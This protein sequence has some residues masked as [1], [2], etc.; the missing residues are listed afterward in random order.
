MARMHIRVAGEDCR[1]LDVGSRL[2][3]LLADGTGG[4]AM[5]TAC[6]LNTRRY[7]GHLVA[8]V[9]PPADRM[10]LLD[11][12]EAFAEITGTSYPLA[13][14][15]YPGALHPEGYRHL[16]SFEATDSHVE[17]TFDLGGNEV[18]KRLTLTPEGCH[19]TFENLSKRP[20][21][22]YVRPLVCHK[23]YHANFRARE[24]YPSGLAVDEDSLSI[25]F[26][27]VALRL[28]F[29]GASC[30]ATQGWYY[31]FEHQREKDRGLDPIDDLFCPCELEVELDPGASWTLD[32]THG[33][34]RAPAA[35]S[36]SPF[37]VH[38]STRTS[39]IA[40]YPWFT[41]WGRDTMIS[42][43]GICLASGLFDDARQILRDYASQVHQGLIP[44]RF[45]E[46]G[47]TPEY[48]TVDASLWFV[49]ASYLTLKADWNEDFAREMLSAI[50]EIVDWYR[51]GT[52]YGIGM[53]PTDG[54]ITQGVEGI[55]LTWM[56]AKI[57]DWVVTPRR[58]KPVEING[59]WIHALRVLAWL[60]DR[61]GG[62]GAP[63][64]QAAE[65]AETSFHREFWNEELG[66]YRDT[67]DPSSD[68][69]RPNQVIP[70]AL[71]MG[72]LEPLFA[73][74][75]LQAIE[76]HLL[77]PIGLRTL[78][79]F[80][81]GYKGRFEGPLA[82][83][84]ASYHQGTAWPW[85]LGMYVMACHRVRGADDLPDMKPM[86]VACGLGGVAEV[87]DGDPPHRPNGCPFQA[88]SYA[89]LRQAG[90]LD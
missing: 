72:P 15:Q 46:T 26:G 82:E 70:L 61:L 11:S 22:L 38:S 79:P 8:A 17:W 47:E 42:L 54:L 65:L 69:L 3:W 1:D 49:N 67:I 55:Q 56:D 5:G 64:R 7:H 31:R 80:E 75:A 43:P 9:R 40:G 28:G 34:G 23:P 39:I 90:L 20:I 77:T 44:N 2:E 35:S 24:D 62:N 30:Q 66:W 71:D 10:V 29:A 52:L 41:D 33:A 48:N 51:V 50:Q 21:K 14:N 27:H 60:T 73:E 86:L 76:E 83:L 25:G 6:G 85:L 18:R 13:T 84:D 36:P 78:A 58:G 57:G 81:D 32:A 37:L 16:T 63:D 53:D 89:T 4:Y 12:V 45:V 19:V 87:Y 74:A 68:L 59:L 88:W